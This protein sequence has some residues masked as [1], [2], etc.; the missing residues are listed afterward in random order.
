MTNALFIGV[1]QRHRSDDGV[2]PWIA[3]ALSEA[4]IDAMSHEGDGCG[5]IDLFA[6]SPAVVIADAMQSGAQPGHVLRLTPSSDPVPRGLFRNSTHEFGLAEAIET[7]RHL[8]ALP[9]Q[10]IVYGIEGVDFSHGTHLKPEVRAAAEELVQRV[11][12]ECRQR[13]FDEHMAAIEGLRARQ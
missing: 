5:L 10:L 2:G 7:A 11:W 3:D 1:G 8:G 9:T 4:G 6:Q 13:P 12:T